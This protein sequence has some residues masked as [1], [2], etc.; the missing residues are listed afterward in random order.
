[1]N[2]AAEQEKPAEDARLT[3]FFRAYLDVVF[4]NEPLKASRLGDHRY[5]DK[6]DDLSPEVRA[7]SVEHDRR[8]LAA[9]PREIHYDSLSRDGQID[10][11]ILDRHLH[12][13]VWMAE[14]FRPFEDDPRIYGDFLTDSV[15][16]L[17]TRSSLPHAANVRNAAARMA[18]V[19]RLVD[20]A[21]KTIGRPPR[22]KVETAIRQTKGAIDFYKRGFF[23]LA[24]AT[25]G[26]G[27]PGLRAGQAVRALESYLHFLETEVLPRSTEA[28]RLGPETF[29]R[30]LDL[31]LDAGLTAEEIL[32]EAE[33][34]AIR[35]EC[36]MVVVARKLWVQ[37]FP[38]E[39]VPS[40]DKEGRHS[41]VYRILAAVARDSGAPANLIADARA[42]VHAIKD[43]ITAKAI[44]RLPD[45]DR[46]RLIE[47][48]EFLRGNSVA[49]LNPAPPLDPQC[50][51]EFAISPP[52]AEWSPE[53]VAS[54][55]QEYNQAMLKILTIHEAYPGH[56]V[57]I[58]YSNRHPSLVRK[59]LSSGTFAEGWAVYTEQ[60]MLDEGFG[61]GDLGLRLQQLKF[62]LRSVV[63]AIL[64]Q[65]MHIG[66]M[67]DTQA[68]DL[69]VVRA[70]QSEQEAV[71]K[72]VRAKQS[73]CQLSTYF[74]GRTA[75]H[76]LRQEIQRDQ[77]DRFNLGRY[78]EAVLAH[79]TPPVRFL[80]ELVRQSLGA[81]QK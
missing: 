43:F 7:A 71:G 56:Y 62:Y 58:E 30:M 38:A 20:T 28:W 1:M 29:A 69:L 45:P 78:H 54:F 21:C 34:E 40:D 36:E 42:N 52:P 9:L 4:R 57:Q 60:M 5:D 59:V 46:C 55:F 63:N 49:R 68:M 50:S 39:P 18:E 12:R 41:L 51:S 73:P 3:A 27:E 48:P 31:E 66:A 61:E 76:R 77:G 13:A 17:L 10:Y 75:F 6:L 80:P 22:V 74:V 79:G 70:F 26:Q 14:T 44:L 37:T 8:A 32:R 2:S 47:M 25:P 67:T 72:I 33:A 23:I 16:L 35:V 24:G 65:A 19:P 11:E 64:D 53:Q 81:V 15:Y